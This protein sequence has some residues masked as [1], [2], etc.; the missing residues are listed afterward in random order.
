MGIRGVDIQI[1]LQNT[2]K[3]EEFQQA[4]NAQGRTDDA[5]KRDDVE[6]ERLR[7]QQKPEETE[8]TDQ[9]IVQRRKEDKEGKEK[10]SDERSRDDIMNE[11]MGVDK[12]REET[13]KAPKRR[14]D[15]LAW[16][17]PGNRG[18]SAGNPPAPYCFRVTA[19]HPNH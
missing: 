17:E 11:D 2:L 15:I 7:R 8:K 3:A 12:R 6:Q 4:Q 9:V 1:A 16:P 5:G 10:E 19:K 13:K 14:L 18:T